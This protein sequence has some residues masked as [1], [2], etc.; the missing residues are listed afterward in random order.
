MVFVVVFVFG[1]FYL[2]EIGFVEVVVFVCFGDF[3]VVVVG[4]F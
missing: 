3:L 4:V 2:G 1:C